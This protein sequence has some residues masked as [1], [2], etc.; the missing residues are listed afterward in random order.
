MWCVYL[1]RLEYF[2]IESTLLVSVDV[3]PLAALDAAYIAHRD[4]KRLVSDAGV[5]FT[6]TDGAMLT[7]DHLLGT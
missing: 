5:V 1:C 3:A 4:T 7:W 2:A 6:V